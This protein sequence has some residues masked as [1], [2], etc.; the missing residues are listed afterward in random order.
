MSPKGQIFVKFLI[1]SMYGEEKL[2]NEINLTYQLFEKH[3]N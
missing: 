2:I 3:R 1:N